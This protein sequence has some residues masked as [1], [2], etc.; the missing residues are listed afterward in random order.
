[1]LHVE[2][3]CQQAD[4]HHRSRR[5]RGNPEKSPPRLHTSGRIDQDALPRE[6]ADLER[7]L[8]LLVQYFSDFLEISHFL[9][10]L[11]ADRN[12]FLHFM[13]IRFG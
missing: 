1:M 10:T 8:F 11:L 13:N 6:F 3:T 5:Y 7:R 9:G 12:V 4:E 2:N